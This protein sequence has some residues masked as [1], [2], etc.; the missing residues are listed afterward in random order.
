MDTLTITM[1]NPKTVSS[2]YI[3]WNASIRFKKN[4]VILTKDISENDTEIFIKKIVQAIE[5]EETI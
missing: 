1:Y 3:F 2:N 5:K 4:D